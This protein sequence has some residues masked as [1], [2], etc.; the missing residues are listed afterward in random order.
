[1]GYEDTAVFATV[2]IQEQAAGRT[3]QV[4]MEVFHVHISRNLQVP[5]PLPPAQLLG[6]PAYQPGVRCRH[7][8]A[9]GDTAAAGMHMAA[10]V[11]RRDGDRAD[12][13]GH[14]ADGAG[15]PR[16]DGHVPAVARANHGFPY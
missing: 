5:P 12:A 4:L 7:E 1:M 10:L 8:D 6:T 15:V 3:N 14:A 16:Q 11:L 9:D 2:L 13:D